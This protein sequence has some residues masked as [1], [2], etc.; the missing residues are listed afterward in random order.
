[1]NELVFAT[2]NQNKLN[3]VQELL[4]NSFKL[5]SLKDLNFR[6]DIPETGETLETNALQKAI[7]INKKFKTDVFADDTGLEITALD[8]KPGVFSARYAGDEKNSFANIEK[9]LSQLRNEQDRRAKFR[10][11]IALIINNED[12]LFEGVAEGT[13]TRSLRGEGGFGYDP[14][15]QPL[16]REKTFAEMTLKEKNVI[17]H[18][19]LAFNKLMEFLKRRD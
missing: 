19:A 16:G 6:K 5:L 14:V 13:I 8:G 10:T 1:M 3:E 7:F 9:V 2:N 15:F 17:S 4:G 11:V 18:R 12:Y